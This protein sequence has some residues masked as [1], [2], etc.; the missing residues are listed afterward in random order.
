MQPGTGAVVSS[1]SG[2]ARTRVKRDLTHSG[3]P[4]EGV[5]GTS[6]CHRRAVAGQRGAARHHFSY[7]LRSFFPLFPTTA[8]AAGDVR[9][10][11]RT[12]RVPRHIA[13]QPY[14]VVGPG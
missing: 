4:P 13:A 6:T 2:S 8:E 7:R 1:M 12:V 9:H 10:E 14:S 11:R 3:V 5:H